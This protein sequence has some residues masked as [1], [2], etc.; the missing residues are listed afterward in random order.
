LLC[1]PAAAGPITLLGG[2]A[3]LVT[4]STAHAI[5]GYDVPAAYFDKLERVALAL[6]AITIT[7]SSVPTE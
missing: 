7:T 5:S 2:A 3:V 4:A 1:D 6:R